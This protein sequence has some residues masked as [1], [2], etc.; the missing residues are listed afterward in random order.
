MAAMLSVVNAEAKFDCLLYRAQFGEKVENMSNEIDVIGKACYSVHNSGKFK[1][2]LVYV[3]RL[4]NQLNT[5]GGGDTVRA[6]TLD[7]LLKLHEVSLFVF[8]SIYD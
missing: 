4:G 2:L 3:L 1:R 6:I 8:L 5:A 7:S